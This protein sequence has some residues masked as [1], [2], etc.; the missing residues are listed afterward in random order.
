MQTLFEKLKALELPAGQYAVFGS[1]PLAVRGIIP[2][3][4]DLDVICRPVIWE[5]IKAIGKIEFLPEY[6]VEVV[7][8]DDSEISFG[9]TW[10][11]GDFDIDELVSTAEEI[12]GLPFVRLVH[13]VAYKKI[14]GNDKDLRHLRALEAAGITDTSC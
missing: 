9:T 14:R 8:L 13:V 5:Q 6:D 4:N 10:G 1:G 7:H 11:I 3:A 12:D 2:I